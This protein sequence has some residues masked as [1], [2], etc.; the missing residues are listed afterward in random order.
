MCCRYYMEMSPALRPIVEAAERSKLRENNLDWLAKKVTKEGEVRPDDLVPVLATGKSG[1]KKVFPMIWGYQVA[2]LDRPL[3]NARSETAMEKKTFRESWLEH[4]CIVPASWYYEWEHFTAP[5][6]KKETGKKYAIM[7]KGQELTWLC[8]LYRLENNY[9][10]FVIL[11]REPGEDIAFIHDRMP[12]ILPE[13]AVMDWIDP[14]Y[15]PNSFLRQAIT[16]CVYEES[17]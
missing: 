2:G 10:H 4:R 8:G 5:N 13:G 3:I 1:K 12:L 14:R 6:G 17:S 7:P 15:S 16:D 11:T 9:P